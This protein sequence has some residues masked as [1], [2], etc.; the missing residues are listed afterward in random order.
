VLYNQVNSNQTANIDEYEKSVFLTK[1]EH[2]FV[3]AYFDPR[4]NKLVEGFDGSEKRQ[5][6]FST[7]VINT[8]LNEV[9]PVSKYDPR[10]VVYLMPED[11]FLVLNESIVE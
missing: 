7:L 10:S 1:A 3:K 9:D 4:S 5:Y 6:D 11:M 2:E 8:Q